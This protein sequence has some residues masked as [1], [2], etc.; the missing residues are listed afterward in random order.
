MNIYDRGDGR[1]LRVDHDGNPALYDEAGLAAHHERF[2]DLVER[3]IHADPHT[4]TAAQTVASQ[5]ELALLTKEF[6]ATDRA[7]PPT[8]LIGPIEAR[9]ARTP[10]ATA[11][12]QGRT[13][14]SYG[15]LN[16][17]A[18]RLARHLRTLGARPGAVVVA[19]PRS[20]D[21][22]VSLL[23][24]LKSGAAF[25][26]LDPEDPEPRL[27]TPPG[28]RRCARSPTGRGGCPGP[29]GRRWWSWP[30]WTSPAIRG[31]TRRA[32]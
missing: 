26:P 16:T 8:T 14:L 9:A 31:P 23:A 20:V 5:A 32:P 3:L 18:N 13:A 21:L 12:I 4:P 24:V 17:R 7:L 19:V 15:E 22:V 6:D 11:L 28:G 2:L 30:V 10:G 25:L 29:P 1:G 27:A